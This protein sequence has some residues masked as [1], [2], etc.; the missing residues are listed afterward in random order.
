[1]I[2]IEEKP[3]FKV[4]IVG[5]GLSKVV[6]NSTLLK[7]LCGPLKYLVPEVFPGISDGYGP[8]D[9]IWPGYPNV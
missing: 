8:P 9:D 7:T 1:M 5:F 6:T 2:E 3:F 4:V